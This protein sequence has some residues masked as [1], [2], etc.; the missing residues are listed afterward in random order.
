MDTVVTTIYDFFNR[1]LFS[2]PKILLLPGII[3]RQPL[4]VAQ[5]T[6]FIFGSDFLKG[7]FMTFLTENIEKLQREALEVTAVR[8]KVEAFDMKN[9]ELLQRSGSGATKLPRNDGRN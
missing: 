7:K 4:L 8:T 2:F 6:P 9:A 1:K 3:M 5:I